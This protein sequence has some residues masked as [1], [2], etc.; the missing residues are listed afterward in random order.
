M[1]PSSLYLP[2]YVVFTLILVWY[3]GYGTYN[4]TFLTKENPQSSF[5]KALIVGII[6][7]IFIG[8]RPIYLFEEA[9]V[10]TKLAD[11]PT[12][13]DRYIA[14]ADGLMPEDTDLYNDDGS[15]RTSVWLFLFIRNWMA[16]NGFSANLWLTV[17]AAIYILPV[18]FAL[19]LLTPNYIYLGLLF[20][21]VSL[22]FYGM[23]IN[24]LKSGDA[25]SVFLFGLCI[26][27]Y[28]DKHRFYSPQVIIGLIIAASSYLFHASQ[29]MSLG[30][31]FAALTFV[32]NTKVA[33]LIWLSAIVITL[34]YGNALALF[35]ADNYD[36][37]RLDGYINYNPAY[38]SIV[39]FRWDFLIYSA[40]PI[41]FGWYVTITR[42]IRDKIYQLI[43][44]TYILTNSIFV[45]FMYSI[46]PNRFAAVSWGILPIVLY[47][48][49][50][51]YN[52]FP[53][54]QNK[55]ASYM[56]FGQLFL[57]IIVNQ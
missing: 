32:R 50:V 27:A 39:R 48:P 47:Y 7:I 55:I 31:L 43:L 20:W 44:N 23:G 10:L 22:N 37:S 9:G 4:H 17:V 36:D 49:L 6:F 41:A 57:L 40:I 38:N 28:S 5:N 24:G 53:G 29:L 1:I 3:K 30:A 42:K 56:L 35:A 15:R 54:A 46:F 18:I 11:T 12:Y 2:I 52:L 34:I 51:K 21:L 45:L 33:V 26:I 13:T 19:R 25:A 16:I 14:I 8:F